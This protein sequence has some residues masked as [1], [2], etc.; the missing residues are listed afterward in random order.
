LPQ[1]MEAAIAGRIGR[2]SREAAGIAEI[3]AVIG[4]AFD[5]EV[6]S[7]AAGLREDH[8]LRGLDELLDCYLVVER[9]GT[10]L[11]S[12]YDFSFAHEIIR[13]QLYARIPPDLR[14]RRHRRVGI[15]MEELY[16]PLDAAASELAFHFD[17]GA[18]PAKAAAY[19]AVVARNALA[20]FADDEAKRALCRALEIAGGLALR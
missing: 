17:E 12:R 1:S 20:V 14:V 7:A 10:R 3:A 8:V 6:V 2:L 11:G 4:Q 5:V 16:A 19:Y 18:E 13:S 15:V 9:G